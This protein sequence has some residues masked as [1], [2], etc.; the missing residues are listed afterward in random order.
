MNNKQLYTATAVITS[1]IVTFSKCPEVY[2]KLHMEP[3]RVEEG[4]L[5]HHN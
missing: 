4:P 2:K 3:Q 5:T 1:T